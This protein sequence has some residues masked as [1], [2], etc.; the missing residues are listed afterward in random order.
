MINGSS[1]DLKKTGEYITIQDIVKKLEKKGELATI[2]EIAAVFINILIYINRH[3][4]PIT[5]EGISDIDLGLKI[6]NYM[7]YLYERLKIN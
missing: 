4:I 3:S 5:Q 6:M 1:A 7:Y 2:A